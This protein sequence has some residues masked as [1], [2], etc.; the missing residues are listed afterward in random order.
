MKFFTN[1]FKTSSFQLIIGNTR[2]F[3]FHRSYLLN[4]L[5][6]TEHHITSRIANAMDTHS[7]AQRST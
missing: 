1:H 2:S 4:R 6:V 3:E 7:R 5:T